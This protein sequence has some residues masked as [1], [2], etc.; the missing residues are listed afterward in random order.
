MTLCRQQALLWLPYYSCLCDHWHTSNTEPACLAFIPTQGHTSELSPLCL[1]QVGGTNSPSNCSTT[2]V[3]L[4][5][6]WP[7]LE[8]KREAAII[9]LTGP[10]KA[11]IAVGVHKHSFIFERTSVSCA[12]GCGS[13][14]FAVGTYRHQLTTAPRIWTGAD[15]RVACIVALFWCCTC[16]LGSTGTHPMLLITDSQS[17]GC[18]MPEAAGPQLQTTSGSGG[19]RPARLRG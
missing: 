13:W 14:P 16:S 15:C 3:V 10:A 7:S 17:D 8:T 11:Q 18:W 5:V 2:H 4:L 1:A 6:A 19:L 9:K 12:H